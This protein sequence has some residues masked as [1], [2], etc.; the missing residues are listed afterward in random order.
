MKDY[1][2]NMKEEWVYGIHVIQ[3]LL[4][5]SPNRV[6]EVIFLETRQDKRLEQ[7]KNIVLNQGISYRTV[8]AKQMMQLLGEEK[9]RDKET[10]HQGLAARIRTQSC[11]SE[12]DLLEK[13]SEQKT[14]PFLLVLDNIQDPQ[15]LGACLR[16][17]DATG[18][19]AVI[20][21][22]D[23]SV[24]LTPAVR[25]VASGAAESVPVVEVT[26][27]V[28]FLET[29]KKQGV[30]IIGATAEETSLVYEVDLKGPIAMVFGAE[31]TGM[32]RLT[33]EH[34]D[35]LMRIPMCGVVKS[36]NVS[37]AVGVC[38]YEAVRQRRK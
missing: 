23:R 1:G 25:K 4:E 14:P 9:E 20:I 36:L 31:G 24:K 19:N 22:K 34:C 3:S 37:V 38:L 7:I 28:R 26:N 21:P 6:L 10:Q 11:L 33:A 17:A 15:N 27:L 12:D 13:L 30:W 16:T 32:R 5:Q 2:K 35:I 8:N 29:L 18:V